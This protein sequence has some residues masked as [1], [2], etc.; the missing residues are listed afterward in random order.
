M[1]DRMTSRAFER[2]W[3]KAKEE[4]RLMRQQGLDLIN[5]SAKA[6]TLVD[7]LY[8]GVTGKEAPD[9]MDMAS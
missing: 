2:Q 9:L 6:E 4:I 8:E 3:A 7:S 5:A 1:P